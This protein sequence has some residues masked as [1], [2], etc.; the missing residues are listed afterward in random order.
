MKTI[1]V[2]K[3]FIDIVFTSIEKSLLIGTLEQKE[4]THCLH[5]Q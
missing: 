3:L 5:K 4:N 2:T 1:V